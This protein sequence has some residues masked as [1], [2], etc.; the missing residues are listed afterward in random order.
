MS[1]EQVVNTPITQQAVTDKS[2]I[3]AGTPD[4]AAQHLSAMIEAGLSIAAVV[5]QPDR[6]AKRGKKLQ[7]SPVKA[8][9]LSHQLTVLQPERLRASDIASFNPWLMVV[10]AYG[11]ILT[12][13][14]IDVPEMGC[15]NVHASLL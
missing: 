15:I 8:L 5:T 3:F 12:Q 2:I 1:S 10:V 9:A 13:S 11:Q 14:V 7:M 4:F 6:P